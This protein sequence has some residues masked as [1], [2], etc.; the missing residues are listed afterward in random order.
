MNRNPHERKLFVG[1]EVENTLAKGKRTLFLAGAYSTQ[2]AIVAAMTHKAEQIYLAANQSYGART[3]YEWS[4]AW[5]GLLVSWDKGFVTI[6]VP[7]QERAAF[8]RALN[9]LDR[10]TIERRR[11]IIQY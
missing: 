3:S 11:A 6:D 9:E 4:R 8:L 2:E 7:L 1:T 10:K 5:V